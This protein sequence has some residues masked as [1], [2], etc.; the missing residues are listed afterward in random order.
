[1][2]VSSRVVH[3]TQAARRA[4]REARIREY[5][6]L[7]RSGTISTGRICGSPAYGSTRGAAWIGTN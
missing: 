3:R 4:F 5:F 7:R 1:V 6:A 2:P